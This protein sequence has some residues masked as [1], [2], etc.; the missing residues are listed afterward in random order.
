ML[1]KGLRRCLVIRATRAY[2]PP[3][4]TAPSRDSVGTRVALRLSGLP[5]V[6]TTTA[7]QTDPSAP[8]SRTPPVCLTTRSPNR[9]VDPEFDDASTS[10]SV[11]LRGRRSPTAKRQVATPEKL[12]VRQ[13]RGPTVNVAEFHDAELHDTCPDRRNFLVETGAADQPLPRVSCSNPR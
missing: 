2:S 12:T 1:P 10:A 4:A 11:A 9:G 13:A 8:L 3:H 5:A 6:T 7:S